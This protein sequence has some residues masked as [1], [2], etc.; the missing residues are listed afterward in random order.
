MN[1]LLSEPVTNV[2]RPLPMAALGTGLFPAL[3]SLS[4]VQPG[5]KEFFKFFRPGE[6][7][8]ESRMVFLLVVAQWRFNHT[9]TAEQKPCSRMALDN[10][11]VL[12][13]K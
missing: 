3:F 8:C 13:I 2:L 1:L 12:L 9:N 4:R 11:L 6:H 5:N 7:N 10:A